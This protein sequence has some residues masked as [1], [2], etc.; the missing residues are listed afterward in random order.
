MELPGYKRPSTRH[1]LRIV[2]ERG[3]VFI[4]QAGTIILAISVVLWA[5]A[6]FPRSEEIASEAAQKL[7]QGAPPAEVDHWRSSQQ[8]RQ[9]YAGKLGRAIEPAIEPL[10]FDWR[11]GI[12]IIASFAAREV[13]VSTMAIVYSVGD[14]D[15]ASPLL[16][17]KLRNAKRPDGE[18]VF[19]WL[20]ALSL[21]V[22]FVLACQCMSTLAIVKRETNSWR[23]P[24]FM[25]AYM[26]VLAYVGS[27]VVY[28][29]GQAL[30][31][32]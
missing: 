23:W 3:W 29:G 21:M 7:E 15:E 18:P 28:Q 8:I 20:S 22:F 10:G 2:G 26:T 19:S 31:F 12:G 16:R 24:I 4:R 13:L 17:E 6:Y 25:F 32:G 5:L 14:E 30:G 11:T 27:L 1:L 9:S